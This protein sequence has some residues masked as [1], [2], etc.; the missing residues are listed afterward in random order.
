MLISLWRRIEDI[1]S[2]IL[3]PPL[4]QETV[5]LDM[6]PLAVKT[7]NVLQATIAINAITSERV[8]VVSKTSIVTVAL[9]ERTQSLR[10]TC[11]IVA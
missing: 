9:A 10:T 3:L 4:T 8:G 7:Y 6:D 5:L 1:E 2:E 11:S